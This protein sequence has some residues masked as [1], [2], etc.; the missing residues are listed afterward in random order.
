VPDELLT[1][2]ELARRTAR[3][4]SSI[5][6]YEEIGLLPEPVRVGGRRRYPE[7][8]VRTLTVVDAARRAGLTLSEIRTLLTA[9]PDDSAAIEEL[10]GIAERKLPELEATIERA[11]LVR[12]WLEA[13]ARCECPSLDECCLFELEAGLPER[14]PAE[15]RSNGQ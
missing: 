3:R 13:A 12:R 8:T 6:Y 7:E 2:G 11:V 5:R 10:R 15:I 14:Q 4:T 9:A 1:I